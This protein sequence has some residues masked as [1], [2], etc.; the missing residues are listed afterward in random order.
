MIVVA[1]WPAL[2][3]AQARLWGKRSLAVTVMTLAMLVIIVAPVAVG[4]TT[5]VEQSD[6]VVAWSKSLAHL[7]IPAPPDWVRTLPLVGDRIVHEWQRVASARP[8]ELAARVTPYLTGVAVWILA[9]AG[10]LGTLF[11]QLLLT[12]AISAILYSNGETVAGAVLAFARRLAGDAGERVAVLS[13][14]A[15]RAVALGIVVTALVQS[16]IG[17]IGLVVTGVP[18][19]ALLTAAM[20]LLGVAQIGP[21]PVLIC[22]VIWLYWRDE[23]LWG[24][25]LVVWS[26]ITAS[27]DN[28]LRPVL[29]RKGAH[30]P[31]LLIFA[32]V[33]GGLLAFGIIGLFVGPVVLAVTYTLLQ[34]WV[35]G[36]E[37]KV[38]KAEL[39]PV[40]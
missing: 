21:A 35:K 8:E 5:I 4:V 3:G 28:F 39:P 36:P 23:T 20:F 22:S 38:A 24:T 9:Q 15:I 37:Q 14:Q 30:L 1:T 10:S 16:I 6:T 31:L 7:S 12:V 18:H 32:G 40:E 34:A 2:R 17:G 19:A 25:V 26:L 29:I 27:L 13:A 11:I 33:L